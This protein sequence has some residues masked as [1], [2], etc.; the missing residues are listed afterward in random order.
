MTDAQ[1]W[2]RAD[3]GVRL[4]VR[5]HGTG[6]GFVLVHG[7]GGASHDFD[8]HLGV[9]GAQATVVSF[10]LRGHGCS[11]AP[12][13]T[14]RYSLDRL[15][16]DTLAVL[17]ALGMAAVD[18]LGHSLGGMV[19]RRVLR[20]APRRVGRVVLM[21]TS[22]GPPPG[23][24]PELVEAGA[25][26]AERDGMTALRALMDELDPLGSPAYQRVYAGRPGFAEYAAWKWSRLAPAAWAALTR[27]IVRQPDQLDALRGLPIPALVLV[28]EQDGQ[29]LEPSR[30]IAEAIPAPFV[31]IPDAGH[32]P[33]FE[34]GD[35]WRAALL[36]FLDTTCL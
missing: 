13:S 21:A 32:S 16:L 19:V 11:D 20:H 27:E 28:G 35:A 8:D 6:P 29:F 9:L 5:V 22:A 33:Q 25:Q 26:I 10:D 3:D 12:H 7:I 30:V 4:A 2:V 14:D 34:N 18:M 17:D 15:A 1:L 31:V 36:S 23:L 24:D